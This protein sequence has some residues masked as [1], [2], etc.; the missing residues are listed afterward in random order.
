M[1]LGY[2]IAYVA[3]VNAS[4][5]FFESAFGFKRKFITPEAD[6]G[7][8]DTGNTTLS[9]AA[10]VLGAAH[11]PK[12]YIKVDD[13]VLPL[14]IEI[15]LITDD[16]ASAH[17]KAIAL[18]ATQMCAPEQKPWGQTVSYVRSPDGLLIELCT[19]MNG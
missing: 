10:H 2:T 1:K 15:A 18:G 3:D 19:P 14:G 12:G 13:S 5:V 11:F 6:Y 8:L 7:E 16:V 9:F 4:I 17:E